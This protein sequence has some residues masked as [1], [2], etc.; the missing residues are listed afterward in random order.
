MPGLTQRFLVRHL[1]GAGDVLGLWNK[2]ILGTA[3]ALH[4][5]PGMPEKKE[6]KAGQA[7]QLA[8]TRPV[9]PTWTLPGQSH[10]NKQAIQKH[11]SNPTMMKNKAGATNLHEESFNH[12]THLSASHARRRGTA[13]PT[14]G[15]SNRPHHTRLNFHPQIGQTVPA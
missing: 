2:R 13:R 6:F 1:A 4:N 3:I 10:G 14:D 12:K 7:C 15:K 11:G 9:L 8:L 5:S